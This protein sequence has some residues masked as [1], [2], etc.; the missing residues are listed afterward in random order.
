MT[1]EIF[2]Y[3]TKDAL[4]QAVDL[5]I[6]MQLTN[7]LRDIGEDLSRDRIYLAQDEL[8]EFNVTEAMIINKV[9]DDS[10]KSMMK[11]Q[12]ERAKSYYDSAFQGIQKLNKDSRLPVYLAHRN[13]SRIL[14]KIEEN[15]YDVYSQRAYLNQSEK[16]SILPQVFLDLQKAS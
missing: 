1:S 2:G 8:V 7:I 4:D 14:E 12:I 10:F 9:N 16:L 5:G 3:S 11:F 15:N 13:Y 6:A